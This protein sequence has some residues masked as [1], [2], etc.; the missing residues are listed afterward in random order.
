M[1]TPRRFGG[2][3]TR[4]QQ[5]EG[6]MKKLLS[7]NLIVVLTLV[8]ACTPAAPTPAPKADQK[9]AEAPKTA[10]SCGSGSG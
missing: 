1:N 4:R 5:M 8:A 10:A 7:F 2:R 3:A 6:P 9:P